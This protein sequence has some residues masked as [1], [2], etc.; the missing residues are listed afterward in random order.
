MAEHKTAV[1]GELQQ[2]K[3]ENQGIGKKLTEKEQ[4]N[5]QLKAKLL[6]KEIKEEFTKWQN[7]AKWLIVVGFLI[8]LFTILQFCCKTWTLNYPYKL[9]MWI[10]TVTNTVQK[11]TLTALM[12]AP[13]AGL[14]LISTFAWNRL[15]SKEKKAEKRKEI[16]NELLEK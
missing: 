15:F 16:R 14:W 2:L 13:L 9:V 1:S 4:E 6:E 12:Y 3:D 10:D 5:T 7:P 8:I 11:N